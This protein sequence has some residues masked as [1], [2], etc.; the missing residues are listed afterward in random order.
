M[1]IPAAKPVPIVSPISP[2]VPAPSNVF[3]SV[4]KMPFNPPNDVH[5]FP[6]LPN[7]LLP[8]GVPAVSPIPAPIIL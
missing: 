2:M 6:K 7:K 3:K 1:A 8:I 5:D 4:V